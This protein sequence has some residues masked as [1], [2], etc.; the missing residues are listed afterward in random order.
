MLASMP[1]PLS[2]DLRARVIRF[3]EN[4]D[5]YAQPEIAEEFGVSVSTVEKLLR[6]WRTTGSS[7]AL[8]PGGGQVAIPGERIREGVPSAY[9]SNYKVL[10]AVGLQG[11]QAPWV[12]EGAL[13]GELFQTYVKELLLPTLK[14]GDIVVMDNLPTHK[15]AGIAELI[16]T[17]GT[18]LEYLSPYSPDYNPI[19]RCW[20]KI[21][22]YLRKV[23]AR[24]YRALLKALREAFT[25]I[26]KKDL[27]AWAVYCGHPVH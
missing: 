23:N 17:R 12:I 11:V 15:V 14:R 21:K 24:T 26:T 8:A 25:S 4:H 27:N 22:T 13:N 18:R 2:N 9:G 16:A 5:D 3:Y 20:S 7:E 19:E 6:R 1:K 10:A